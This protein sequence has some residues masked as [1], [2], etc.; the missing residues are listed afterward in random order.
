MK[1]R[2]EQTYHEDI[3]PVGPDGR[4]LFSYSYFLVGFSFD[5]AERLVARTYVDTPSEVHFLRLE[6]KLARGPIA[7]ADFSR[8]L[9]VEAIEYLRNSGRNSITWLSF[10][11]EAYIPVPG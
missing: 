9:F 7:V 2:V 1:L 4:R 8:P 10:E 5:N 11:A 3:G 6:G